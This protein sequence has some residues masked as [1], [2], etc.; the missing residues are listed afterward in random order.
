MLFGRVIKQCGLLKLRSKM[1]NWRG[2]QSNVGKHQP[3]LFSGMRHDIEN[4]TESRRLKNG[5][6]IRLIEPHEIEE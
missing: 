2:S 5:R 3:I 1:L 6:I 4:Q